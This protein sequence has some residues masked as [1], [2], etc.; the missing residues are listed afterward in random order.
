[1]KWLLILGYVFLW[2]CAM[3]PSQKV[4]VFGTIT[5]ETGNNQLVLCYVQ[6]EIPMKGPGKA[7]DFLS[8]TWECKH[9]AQWIPK[10]VISQA[11]FQHGYDRRRW[12]SK[13]Q[14]FDPST[15]HAVLQIGEEGIPD[16]TGALQVHY[17]W[18]EWDVLNNQQLRMIRECDNPFESFEKSKGDA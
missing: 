15:G 16:A 6:V 11:D 13:L 10:V 2:G 4:E 3:A 14:S 18:R 17:S 7:Y 5:D 12:V 8:L 1:M 9:G